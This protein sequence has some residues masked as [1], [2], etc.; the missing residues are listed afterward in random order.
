M[1]LTHQPDNLQ[2]QISIQHCQ[3]KYHNSHH[4][5]R[6]LDE[7]NR[8]KPFFEYL[9]SHEGDT[10]RGMMHPG[11]IATEDAVEVGPMGSGDTGTPT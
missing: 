5:R 2:D 7:L 11:G 6:K 4:L 1:I 9:P 8:W 10:P 3:I